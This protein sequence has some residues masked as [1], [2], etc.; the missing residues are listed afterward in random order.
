MQATCIIFAVIVLIRFCVGG[1]QSK[2][3]TLDLFSPLPAWK[4]T[5]QRSIRGEQRNVNTEGSVHK[6][7]RKNIKYY[8]SDSSETFAKVR[9]EDQKE[10]AVQSRT[11]SHQ[12]EK[13]RKRRRP[14]GYFTHKELARRTA[15]RYL[16]EGRFSDEESALKKA[17]VDIR[18]KKRLDSMKSRIRRK[19]VG[20]K[21]KDCRKS[22][23]NSKERV[24]G[25][26]I[27][28][29]LLGNNNV[30]RHEPAR[31]LAEEE[32]AREKSKMLAHR[33]LKKQKSDSDMTK[34]GT[35]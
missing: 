1:K 29:I 15:R 26:K 12:Q 14:V 9:D 23:Y 25:R 13:K 30:V 19:A 27:A 3:E 11:V 35:N 4:E 21:E 24:I 22:G 16:D 2:G 8:E 17:W 28:R 7:K 32:Y 10:H 33:H 34:K 18:E 20:K 31:K 5:K 6:R